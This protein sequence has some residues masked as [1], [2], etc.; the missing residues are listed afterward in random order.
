[1]LLPG[2]IDAHVHFRE[3]GLTHKG[4]VASESKAALAGGVTSVMDMPNVNPPTVT[5]EAL[6]KKLD[7]MSEKSLV[8]YSCYFGATN[9]NHAGF[10]YLDARRVCGI[11]VFMGSSAGNMTV[12]RAESLRR[13]F[14][15]TDMLV[16]VHCEDQKSIEENIRK[17]RRE[18]IDGDLPVEYH[19]RIRSREVCLRASRLAVRLAGESGTRLHLLHISTAEELEL[20]S[21]AVPLSHKRIT[22][23]V[24][25][26]HLL[27]TAADYPALGSRIKCNPAVKDASD[28]DALR[29]GVNSGLIDVVATDHAPHL[30]G[31]KAGGALK[32]ASGMPMVEFSLAC[33]LQL[34]DEGVFTLEKVAEKMC[35]A[36]AEAYGIPNRGYI[37]PG[38]QADIVLVKRAA[39]KV[40]E[41]VILSKCKWSPLEGQTLNYRTEKTFVNGRLAYSGGEADETCRGQELRFEHSA[42][43]QRIPGG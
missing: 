38:Y 21:N 16:A 14:A 29:A 26:P 23:E 25:L 37:R 2:V 20:L 30:P 4:D 6:N 22:G 18:T 27:F 1:L 17:Y 5:L 12:E 10:K 28:R 8:N 39:N 19:S 31:E 42:A 40:T 34:A 3:P 32:A 15:A 11:K 35:H 24:C 9:D 13:I 33:M 7:G 36:P 41:D 43:N